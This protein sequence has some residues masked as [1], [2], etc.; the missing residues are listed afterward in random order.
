MCS[1]LYEERKNFKLFV[2]VKEV[3]ISK[4]L[5]MKICPFITALG[6]SGNDSW[7]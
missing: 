5:R 4:A 3:Q 7:T 2:M 1:V 6:R